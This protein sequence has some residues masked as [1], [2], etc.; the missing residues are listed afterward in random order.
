[1]TEQIYQEELSLPESQESYKSDVAENFVDEHDTNALPQQPYNDN[2]DGYMA[3]KPSLGDK[4]AQMMENTTMKHAIYG[5]LA[6][7]GSIA[8]FF[9]YKKVR[10]RGA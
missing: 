6:A 8:A 5:A 4:W 1:M 10:A 9:V 2:I 3:S 7:V